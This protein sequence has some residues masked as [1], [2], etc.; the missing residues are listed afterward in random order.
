M[1]H[2]EKEYMTGGTIGGGPDPMF[3]KTYTTTWV[4]EAVKYILCLLSF[5]VVLSPIWLPIL[6]VIIEGK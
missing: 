6:L 2:Y 4:R 5:L 1:K 3:G